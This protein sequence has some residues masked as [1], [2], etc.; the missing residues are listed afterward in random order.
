MKHL[1]SRVRS[2]AVVCGLVWIIVAA[3]A[4][5]DVRLPALISDHM[6]LQQ[7][8]AVA[9][10]GSA[11]AGENITVKF[12]GQQVSAVAG[13]DGRWRVFLEPMEAGGPFEMTVSGRNA[14]TL[15]N[16][17]VGEVWVCSGQSNM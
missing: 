2:A 14:I 13:A 16:V 12:R 3:D 6:V 8:M 11:D 5:A 10:W 17:M 9:I 7:G 1:T 15:K 4:R